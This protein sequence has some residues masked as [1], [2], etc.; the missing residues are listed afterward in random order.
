MIQALEIPADALRFASASVELR[1]TNWTAGD[2]PERIP[3]SLK[4]RQ[5]GVIDHWYWGPIIHDMAGLE[6]HKATIPIDYRHNE[7]EILGFLDEFTTGKDNTEDLTVSGYLIPY[8]T[9]DRVAEIVHK[10]GQGVPYEASIYYSDYTLEFLGEDIEATV[11]GL[12]VVGPL[13]IVRKWT[14]RGVAICPYGA[15]KGTETRLA[16]RPGETKTVSLMTKEGQPMPKITP[17]TAKQKAAPPADPNKDQAAPPAEPNKDQATP[18]AE[19]NKDQATPPAEPNKDQAE[20]DKDQAEPDQATG[21]PAG[22]AFLEAFGDLGGRW[23]AEGKTW[24]EAQTL[25]RK[26]QQA[27]IDRLTAERDDATT[28][29]A[30]IDLGDDDAAGFSVADGKA[31]GDVNATTVNT[32]EAKLGA[33]L[34]R[35]AAGIKRPNSS[36]P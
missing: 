28:R 22:P 16:D 33:N 7:D 4:A 24:A 10:A 18:P 14:L 35:A 20:P 5:A 13:Y 12:A 19:P 1:K 8:K 31:A 29:L 34:A 27:E 3:V 32:P 2:E 9:Q 11:N 30:Q 15:D 26:H 17:Q 36:T 25:F 6:F 23:F 21:P